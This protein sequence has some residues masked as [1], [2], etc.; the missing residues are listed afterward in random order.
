[1]H[2]IDRVGDSRAGDALVLLADL[3]VVV[4]R[5]SALV[6]RHALGRGEES[7]EERIVGWKGNKHAATNK[8]T[9]SALERASEA[10]F[11]AAASKPR[12]PLSLVC[13]DPV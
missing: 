3:L 8:Q 4:Q 6:R 5:L 12:C 10:C 13:A 2:G 1:M 7:G 9:E 11:V